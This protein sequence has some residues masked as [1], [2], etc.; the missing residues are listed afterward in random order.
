MADSTAK[1]TEDG[2]AGSGW[3]C[4]GALAVA[5]TLLCMV[6]AAGVAWRPVRG[7]DLIRA[8]AGVGR[9]CGRGHYASAWDVAR[10]MCLRNQ[11]P[12]AHSAWSKDVASL[13][14]TAP[15]RVHGCYPNC[16]FQGCVDTSISYAGRV[17]AVVIAMIGTIVAAA[18]YQGPEE[19]RSGVAS[20]L[21]KHAPARFAPLHLEIAANAVLQSPH[22]PDSNATL[23]C[24]SP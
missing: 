22:Y 8:P 23:L 14:G 20:M 15:V 18:Q 9:N 21:A 1:T 24:P 16:T 5:A 2:A 6:L 3:A 11:T 12:V 4:A 10:D 17:D 7:L 13:V 19:A